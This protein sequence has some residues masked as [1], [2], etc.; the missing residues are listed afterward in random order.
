M[1]VLSSWRN[2]FDP[3]SIINEKSSFN[4]KKELP[5]DVADR[6]PVVFVIFFY[7]SR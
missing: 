7:T 2:N 5:L 1:E 4:F 6:Y 3:A